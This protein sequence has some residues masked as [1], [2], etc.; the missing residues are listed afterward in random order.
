MAL[1]RLGGFDERPTIIARENKK[2]F[3]VVNLDAKQYDFF[4][5]IFVV[6]ETTCLNEWGQA[7][8]P[9]YRAEDPRLDVLIASS[10]HPYTIIL[11]FHDFNKDYIALSPAVLRSIR[12]YKKRILYC[13]LQINDTGFYTQQNPLREQICIVSLPMLFGG[14]RFHIS[15]QADYEG[16]DLFRKL[17]LKTR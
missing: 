17:I 13:K 4:K 11:D 14:S 6:K 2:F 12:K 7:G 15:A 16:E 1:T 8:I 5:T 9:V 10:I 3:D